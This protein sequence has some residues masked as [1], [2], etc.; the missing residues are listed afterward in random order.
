MPEIYLFLASMLCTVFLVYMFRRGVTL[1]TCGGWVILTCIHGL[2][3]KPLVVYFDFP[4]AAVL[5]DL[6]FQT[7][8]RAE[9]WIW[10][11][12]SLLA[13]AIFF[14]SMNLTARYAHVPDAFDRRD[15][16]LCFNNLAL[17]MFLCIGLAGIVGFFLQFPQ[18][19]GSGNKNVVATVD[20][21]EY[22][23]GGIWRYISE[24]TYVV[25]LCALV[26][27]GAKVRRRLSLVLFF[28]ASG[29]WI[30]FC[31]LSDQRGLLFF[32]TV[33]YLIAYNRYVSR[34]S[35][36]KI[37]V[38]VSLM[39]SVV[40]LKTVAR[41][42]SSAV[43]LRDNFAQTM[44][45]LVGQNLI[46]HAKMVSIIKAIP[47][48]L[49]FQYAYSYV[50][51]VLVLIP[52]SIFPDKPF[53]NLD[54]TIGNAVF[55]CESF[56]A[57][58]VPPGMLAESY[59]NFGV[60]G[61]AIVPIALG[62]MIGKFD[63]EFRVA[64]RGST[65]DIFYLVSVLFLGMGILGSGIAS[66]ITQLITQMVTIALICFLSRKSVRAGKSAARIQTVIQSPS[67]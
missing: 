16:I 64:R 20:L 49:P 15:R 7:A 46:E 12:A 61:L 57:C 6:L 4:N 30:L 51:A 35:K 39:V 55:G 50:N 53:V 48:V 45:N 41:L 27:V 54:T 3:L 63:F 56:G 33:A 44:G 65:F 32:S 10:G 11:T 19:L 9:Y 21:T 36:G 47:D 17:T 22:S 2:L 5:D 42:S 25:S 8:T 14:A 59:L 28:F 34:V 67:N 1:G 37:L 24:Y 43:D 52:R 26:N 29:T 62:L 38:A 58:A 40:L 60:P 31:F 18:L 23:G 13:Y 66:S